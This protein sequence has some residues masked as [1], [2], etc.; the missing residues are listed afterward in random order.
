MRR[1]L[2][3][4]GILLL[5]AMVLCLSGCARKRV[6]VRPDLSRLPATQRPYCINGRWY[7]P[8][9]SAEGYQ[10]VGY[11]SWYGAEFHG[12]PTA[13]GERYDMY[14]VSAAHRILPMNTYLRV[15]NLS[16]GREVV[17]RVNDRGPFAKDRIVDLSHGAAKRLGILGSGIAKVRIEALGEVS[18]EGRRPVRFEPYPD[19]REGRFYVQVGAFSNPDNAQALRRKLA[20][21]YRDVVVSRHNGAHDDLYRVQVFA[22][23]SYA[24]AKAFEALLERNGFAGAFVIAR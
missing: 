21:Q 3:L 5:L 1:S 2:F 7:C 20:R 11:A 24:E 16:N 6:Y 15:V 19:F 23:A 12:R 13:S 4:V 22:S 18:V 8:I 14:G 9:P 17:V 10:E